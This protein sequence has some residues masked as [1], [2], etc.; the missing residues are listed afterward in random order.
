MAGLSTP[1][2]T[3]SHGKRQ[4]TNCTHLCVVSDGPG[5]PRKSICGGGWRGRF[6]RES[7]ARCWKTH[8]AR[9][10]LMG[11]PWCMGVTLPNRTAG[12][13]PRTP[14]SDWPHTRLRHSNYLDRSRVKPSTLPNPT[15]PLLQRVKAVIAAKRVAMNPSKGRHNG[16]I[17]R[18]TEMLDSK[19]PT[20]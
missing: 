6:L 1:V 18:S 5:E 19:V 8:L 17:D 7:E 20:H 13:W 3:A 10:N 15:Q 4:P 11:K 2:I 9:I 14:P 16:R 12:F